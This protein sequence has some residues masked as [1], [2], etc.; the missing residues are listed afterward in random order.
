MVPRV[1][2]DAK[3]KTRFVGNQVAFLNN[4]RSIAQTQKC[5]IFN[6]WSNSTGWIKTVYL[7][8]VPTI[9]NELIIDAQV[10]WLHVHVSIPQVH[11]QSNIYQH[12]QKTHTQWGIRWMSGKFIEFGLKIY[13]ISRTTMSVFS[14]G[15][16]C[17]DSEFRSEFSKWAIVLRRLSL[18]D[19]SSLVWIE[20]SLRI[21]HLCVPYVTRMPWYD[22]DNILILISK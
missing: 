19:N 12:Q 13:S 10:H 1:I 14:W 18:N 11:N 20:N 15:Q 5:I 4:P 22:S 2:L 21:V 8:H 6:E 3:R 17:W 16:Y 7:H 9:R